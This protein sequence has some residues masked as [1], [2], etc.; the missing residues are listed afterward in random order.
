MRASVKKSIALSAAAMTLSF[1]I[2]TAATP[3]GPILGRITD[4]T[5]AFTAARSVWASWAAW[6]PRNT[7]TPPVFNIVP[8]SIAGAT[9]S[10]AARSMRAIEPAARPI[11][12]YEASPLFA[13][14][15]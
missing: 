7:V 1:G 9:I 10:V 2:F 6:S 15:L 3:A 13:E 8:P 11:P 5:A 12:R 14:A 4:F